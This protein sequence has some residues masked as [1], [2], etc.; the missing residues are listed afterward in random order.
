MEWRNAWDSDSEQSGWNLSYGRRTAKELGQ[1]IVDQ[2]QYEPRFHQQVVWSYHWESKGGEE[3]GGL[4]LGSGT[5]SGTGYV[6]RETHSLLEARV[7]HFE[8]RVSEGVG[9]IGVRVQ[10]L[11][12]AW[13]A[14]RSHRD[15]GRPRWIG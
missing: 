2:D 11:L 6:D 14:S 7:A 8:G 15:R 10:E 12:L 3:V 9:Q 13:A 4:V 1:S 5:G